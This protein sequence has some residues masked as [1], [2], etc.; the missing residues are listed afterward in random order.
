MNRA[1]VHQLATSSLLP[2]LFVLAACTSEEA[3]RAAGEQD[4]TA[5][6]ERIWDE[7]A[8]SLMDGDIERWLS[9]WTEDGV[10]MPPGEP[11]V[12]GKEAIR[13]R[14]QAEA[15]RF[16]VDDMEIWNAEVVSAGDWAYARGTYT[17]KLL[18]AGGGDPVPV[19]GKYMTILRKQ[20]DGSWRIHRD[21]FNANVPPS[22]Q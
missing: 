5:A 1:T 18:P 17:A 9:L 3:P 21:I 19:D 12:V 7:Y 20:P 16:A 2:V 4:V 22:G 11:P 13:E 14:N 10:Q 8:S 15:D 6:V